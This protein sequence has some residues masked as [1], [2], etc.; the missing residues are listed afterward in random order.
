M[1]AEDPRS[2]GLKD[3]HFPGANGFRITEPLL[4]G[5]DEVCR[6]GIANVH[7]V[8]TERRFESDQRI[9]KHCLRRSRRY[10]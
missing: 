10:F 4:T 6:T 8:T 9:G 1:S 7:N 2:A 5:L 3:G